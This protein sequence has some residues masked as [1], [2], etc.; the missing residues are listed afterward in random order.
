M[1]GGTLSK[2]GYI[3]PDKGQYWAVSLWSKGL[4]APL[5][6]NKCLISLPVNFSVSPPHLFF[7]GSHT[8]LLLVLYSGIAFGNA[9][10]TIWY[11]GNLL[12]A[13]QEPYPLY[14]HS[15]SSLNSFTNLCTKLTLLTT[16]QC[17]QLLIIMTT[18]KRE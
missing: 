12:C 14:Y 17:V 15:D 7:E 3:N 10:E 16:T 4:F 5:F 11:A 18:I 1:N 2:K 13:R 8:Q 9:R 6:K